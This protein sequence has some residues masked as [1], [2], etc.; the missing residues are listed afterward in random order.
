MQYRARTLTSILLSI[1]RPIRL[2][3]Q[4]AKNI[5]S[6]MDRLLVVK[7]PSSIT[8]SAGG[9]EGEKGEGRGVWEGRRGDCKGKGGMGQGRGEG[10][11]REGRQTERRKG[12]RMGEGEKGKRQGCRNC[13]QRSPHI[14]NTS[15]ATLVHCAVTVL[16]RRACWLVR[17]LMNR[18][19]D[20]HDDT[21]TEHRT[22]HNLT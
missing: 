3:K 21:R 18:L 2:Q 6:A 22:T 14:T 4:Y 19:R 12:Q 16:R 13:M 10:I 5:S 7:C 8:F 15:E 1:I 9:G 11:K 17:V 20:T